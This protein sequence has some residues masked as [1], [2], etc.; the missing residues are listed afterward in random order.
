LDLVVAVGGSTSGSLCAYFGSQ[1]G[2]SGAGPN[3]TTS[4]ERIPT[5]LAVA[6]FS[7]TGE[8]GIAL[9]EHSANYL[10][11]CR[12][13]FLTFDEP[14][15]NFTQ[16]VPTRYV[17]FQNATDIDASYLD[18]DVYPD[19]AVVCGGES[20]ETSP[21]SVEILFGPSFL[22]TPVFFEV[23][24]GANCIESSDF[25][26]DDLTD[27]AISNRGDQTVLVFWQPFTSMMAAD[28]VV[29]VA[30][31]PEGLE[32]GHFN[33]DSNADVAVVASSPSSLQFLFQSLG[34]LALNGDYTRSLS[35]VPSGV[36]TGDMDSDALSD[37]LIL[38]SDDNLTFGFL[39]LPSDPL[40]PSSPDFSLPTGEFPRSALIGN[41]DS[42]FVPD[43][44]IASARSDW[45]GSSIAIYPGRPEGF[46]NSNTTVWT[47]KNYHGTR[48]GSGD[49]DGNGLEDL[50][51]LYPSINSFYFVLDFTGT[52]YSFDLGYAPSSLVVKDFNGDG[53][54]DVLT[55]PVSES[56]I[57]IHNWSSGRPNISTVTS[58]ACSA[59]VS[60][61]SFADFDGD[62]LLDVLAATVSG[63]LEIFV[64]NN[65]SGDFESA[66]VLP[67]TPGIAIESVAV[68]NFNL[69]GLPDIAYTNESGRIDILLNTGQ[70]TRFVL[71]PDLH[72]NVTSGSEFDVIWAGDLTGDHMD[73]IAAMRSGDP[74]IYI[75]NQTDFETAPYPE[76]T[77]A[78]PEYP[79][80]VSLV[81]ATDDGFCDVLAVFPSA[82][83]LFLYKQANSSLPT[84]PSMTFVTG[85][86]VSDVIVGSSRHDHLG[87][88]MVLN[89]GSHSV[90][91]WNQNHFPPIADAGGPYTVAQGEPL[92]FDGAVVTGYS[93]LPFIEY[94]WDFG[95]GVVADW[96]FEQ[97]PVHA[98]ESEGNFNVTLFVRDPADNIAS[99][100]TV[101]NVTD[102]YP[103]L[104]FHWMPQNP[105]EG[106]DIV[107]LDTSWYPDDPAN[108]AWYIDGVVVSEGVGSSIT[109][110]LDDGMH[111]VVLN[112][113]DTDGS[114]AELSQAFAVQQRSPDL[115]ISAPDVVSE[116]DSV[117]FEAI[118]DAWNQGPL[119]SIVDHE[120]NFSYEGG[121]FFTDESTGTVNQ[122]EHIFSASGDYQMFTVAV[123]ATDSDGDW[124]ITAWNIQ[125]LDIGPSPSFY[126]SDPSPSEGLPFNFV[127]STYSWDGA[128]AW[129]W[130]LEYPDL[131][132]EGFSWDP[133]TM[134]QIDFELGDGNYNME[135]QV[136][137]SD[138]D[139]ASF[140]MPFVVEEIAPILSISVSPGVTCDE[141][142]P[143][144][145]SVLAD[146]YDSVVRYDWDFMAFGGEFISDRWTVSPTTLY[147]YNWTGNYT[148]KVR[149]TDSDSSVSVQ[150]IDMEVLDLVLSG[151]F[152][153]FV[154]V[155]REDPENTDAVTFD[156][157]LLAQTYP[158]ITNTLWI[159]GDGER[160]LQLSPPWAAVTWTYDGGQ[161]YEVSIVVTDDDGNALNI[162][163]TLF[164]ISPTIVLQSPASGTVVR[165][166]TPIIFSIGDDTQPLV[167]VKYSVNSGTLTDFQTLYQ[168]ATTDWEDG[169][170]S[171]EVRAGDKDGNVAI[172]R[173]IDITVDGTAPSLTLLWES[174]TA[175]GGDKIN[176]SVNVADA[177]ED[178]GGV[179]LHILFQ[180]DTS[181]TT[182]LM[183]PAGSGVYCALV[184]V[185]KRTGEL[186][187]WIVAEDLGGNTVTTETYTVPVKLHFIDVAWPYM[188][189]A[190]I[191]A[192]LGTGAYFMRE[193][194]IAVDETFVIYGDGRMIAH[195][196]RRLKP[197]MD[198]QVLSGM[199]VAIQDFVKDSFKDQTEFTLR[200]MDFGEKVALVEKGEYVY[201]AVI[202]HGKA[203][204]KV[205]RKMETIVQEI[206]KEFEI[207]LIDW[208]GDLDRV[209]GV[210]DIVK[211]LY[212][213]APLLPD[214]FRRRES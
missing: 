115:W 34:H 176:I 60:S 11:S 155:F 194:K 47:S 166:G 128:V 56:Q 203:S 42:D 40:W 23:G 44:A 131:T 121:A 172:L 117:T 208:D 43:I 46:S 133:T 2:F 15:M 178:Q 12:I 113:T 170:Y 81:D 80:V 24:I 57:K 189:I 135:L 191:A 192:A 162:T 99:D 75:F 165:S 118:V 136:W 190:A 210:N 13:E 4:L 126:L 187:F 94:K 55:T 211:K 101:V 164:M 143:L 112:V 167:S 66:F 52:T 156:A 16:F 90:S 59:D 148:A 214:G 125:V 140:A 159:F 21:G 36:L 188:L 22:G 151:T 49:L 158:D 145:F 209:R 213:R 10:E 144:E 168:I 186:Q 89:S 132:H 153:D 6:D 71:P 76:S 106:R 130:D 93:E 91:V 5:T 160:S 53:L 137:E 82:D 184:E 180:G 157:T 51:M 161:D 109:V 83:L 37:L 119:D 58:L 212:S 31:E 134:A 65:V 9:L 18:S 63:T 86:G 1:N 195:S 202:L 103:H 92:Q 139:T 107:F 38:S 173:N 20:P 68:G 39:Q 62:S 149:A 30:G 102:N 87:D 27:L 108:K 48:I 199:F 150:E 122:T 183:T 197:G 69:D 88:I 146:S 35:A 179:V 111:T 152:D 201:L 67:A 193:A 127:D 105:V 169:A 114:K 95:D 70:E 79:S 182:I 29:A 198:D 97:D 72:L 84:T 78:L 200:K 26:G 54:E 205:A 104:E 100:G 45:S 141:F 110:Q 85:A 19:I 96:S 8:I 25:N 98:Y 177:N 61:V 196:T 171:I 74:L 33:G 77:F 73:D 204:K 123:R 175:Y 28:E 129:S 50:V 181:N 17:P 174:T 185:P 147:Q 7:L 120:W 207:H 138:G 163:E 41:M 64:H 32:A 154:L 142:E 116:G 3:V 206:E 124:N 14:T